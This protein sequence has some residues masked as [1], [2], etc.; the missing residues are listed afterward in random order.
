M[1]SVILA[2]ATFG[3]G[4]TQKRHASEVSQTMGPEVSLHDLT[5]RKA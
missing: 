2:T 4:M 3:D 1:E 5:L